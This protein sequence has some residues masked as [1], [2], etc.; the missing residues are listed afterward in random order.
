MTTTSIRAISDSTSAGV[1][2]PS[3]VVGQPRVDHDLS[4][5]TSG[6][7]VV[8]GAASLLLLVMLRVLRR[9]RLDEH[10]PD[11][12]HRRLLGAEG[13]IRPGVVLTVAFDQDVE[14]IPA[15]R[16]LDHRQVEPDVTGAGEAA[17]ELLDR[18]MRP[19][20][21]ADEEDLA[22]RVRI[23]G[24]PVDAGAEGRRVRD[25]ERPPGPLEPPARD[26]S[27]QEIPRR[28]PRVLPAEP[29]GHE[30]ALAGRWRRGRP[31]GRLRTAAAQGTEAPPHGRR[32]VAS[33]ARVIAASNSSLTLGWK[34][35]PSGGFPGRF[36]R[37]RSTG[38]SR[39]S[40]RS[41]SL[42][43]SCR[44]TSGSS[45]SPRSRWPS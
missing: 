2:K 23:G 28:R 4:R 19:H 33:P 3:G 24:A 6:E 21:A 15:L 30:N 8:H 38:R 32:S 43:C 34:T 35:K 5:V 45:P 12:R 10:D 36:S 39:S 22:V 18:G 25:V 27:S 31:V 16:V 17:Q 20:R 42:G 9:V 40:A 29:A 26:I 44:R 7:Q 11:H 37:S 1:R 14:R 13:K 41:Y